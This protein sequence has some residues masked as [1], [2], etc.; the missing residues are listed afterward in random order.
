VV[1]VLRDIGNR[2]LLSA[3]SKACD[4]AANAMGA[5]L[6]QAIG[7]WVIIGVYIGSSDWV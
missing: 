1:F 3:K 7:L 6:Q 5:V 4:F 2:P